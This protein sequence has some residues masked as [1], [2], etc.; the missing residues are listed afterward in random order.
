MSLPTL[1]PVA[2]ILWIILVILVVGFLLGRWLNRRRS[3]A[4]GEWLQSGIRVFGAQTSWRFPRGISSGGEVKVSNANAPFRQIELGYYLLT[5]EFPFLWGVELLRGKRDMLAMRGDL[6]GMPA[7]EYEVVPM[8]GALR[9]AL[10]RHAGEF[11]WRW[12]EMPAELGMATRNASG[13][14]AEAKVRA[15]LKVYGQSVQRL[16]LR[17]RSPNLVLFVRVSGIEGS[18]AREFLQA[19]RRLL[20]QSEVAEK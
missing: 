17:E 18:P 2:R 1:S 12:V 9:Q 5:R 8:R 11:E 6:R 14:R 7:L 3:K 19:V 4:I 15:F 16:S 20:D 13:A 10:D